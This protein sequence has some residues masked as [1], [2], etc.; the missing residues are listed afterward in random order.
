MAL[1]QTP[2][3]LDVRHMGSTL[4]AAIES[5]RQGQG[6]HVGMHA[7]ADLA[8]KTREDSALR[9]ALVAAARKV[10]DETRAIKQHQGGRTFDSISMAHEHEK[11]LFFGLLQSLSMTKVIEPR[12]ASHYTSYGVGTFVQAFS[13][14]TPHLSALSASDLK[15]EVATRASSNLSEIHAHLKNKRDHRSSG[16]PLVLDQVLPLYSSVSGVPY[17]GTSVEQGIFN[18]VS[19]FIRHYGK[20]GLDAVRYMIDRAT[21]TKE[22]HSYAPW[23]VKNAQLALSNHEPDSGS[24]A[25]LPVAVPVERY[26]YSTSSQQARSN[27][28]TLG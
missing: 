25:P 11:I 26:R 24:A 7:V 22:K 15:Q 16:E 1:R 6:F 10:L 28:I 2:E 18:G 12:D 21:N 8:T 3:S 17:L 20:P 23:L 27:P 9:D 14:S 13:Y 19:D 4:N 5:G